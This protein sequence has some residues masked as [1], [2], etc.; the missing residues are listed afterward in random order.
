MQFFVC[1]VSFAHY[2]HLEICFELHRSCCSDLEQLLWLWDEWKSQEVGATVYIVEYHGIKH[3]LKDKVQYK[4][5][6]WL[7]GSIT[8]IKIFILSCKLVKSHKNQVYS[9]KYILVLTVYHTYIIPLFFISVNNKLSNYSLGRIKPRK[10]FLEV[11]CII[12]KSLMKIWFSPPWCSGRTK[13][14]KTT[15][16]LSAVSI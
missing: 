14:E 3:S 6:P 13:A 4:F 12:L 11:A 16:V 15:K 1:C 2:M 7:K 8:P 10:Y 9:W 5:L